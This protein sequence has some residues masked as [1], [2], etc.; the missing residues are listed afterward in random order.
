ME[1]DEIKSALDK[2]VEPVMTAFEA[3]KQTNDARLAEIEKKAAADPLLDD[4]LARLEKKLADYEGLNQKLTIAQ[5]QAKAAHDAADRLEVAMARIPS[6]ARDRAGRDE[7]KSRAND[8]LRATVRTI[9]YGMHNLSVE[10][11]K[12]V[13]EVIA[14]YKSLNISNDASGSYLAPIEYVRQI[15]KGVT[16]I[17]PTRSLVSVRSTAAKAIQVPK[18]TGQFS[19]QW[20]ADQGT[21]SETT[22]LGYGLEEIPTHEIFALVDISNGM[23]EDAAFDMESELRM[24]AEEQF[25]KAEGYVAIN[26]SGVGRP[27]GVLAHASVAE[28]V[29]G[30]ASAIT[31]DGLLDLFYGIKTAYSRAASWGMNRTTLGAIR[32]LKDGDG[33]YLWMPGLANG[34]PNTINGAPYVELP[35]MPDIA[36]N[37]YPVAFGDWRRAYTLVDRIAMEF[38]RDPYTQATGGNVRY[39]FR[40]RLGG[41]VTLP[42]AIRKLKI[43]A[44]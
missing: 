37:A 28:T 16:E 12:S 36:A 25:A 15:I 43:A 9:N 34:I 23:L 3:F 2:A 39:I 26:G 11:R 31:A 33:Q 19:A 32:K 42:E 17:S 24:E 35:D 30:N 29:S 27:Q 10:E 40:R 21:K 44:S 41:Q 4:K 14:E 5:Q 8:W 20:V 18:R 1:P 6:A 38:L 7:W 13:D 22:G